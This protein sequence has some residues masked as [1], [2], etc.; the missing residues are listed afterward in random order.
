MQALCKQFLL[1]LLFLILIN[2]NFV[3]AFPSYLD[4]QGILR[5]ITNGN[6]INRTET[7]NITIYNYSNDAV[8]YTE[9]KAITVVNGV[10]NYQIGYITPLVPSIFDA[11]T[12]FKTKIDVDVLTSVNFTAVPYSFNSLNCND[13]DYLGGTSSGSYA[14][15]TELSDSISNNMTA[16]KD[17]ITANIT[18]E[19]TTMR[20][21]VDSVASDTNTW[22]TINETVLLNNTNILTINNTWW[23]ANYITPTA[24]A[25][26]ISGN[27]TAIDTAIN[28]NITASDART[29]IKINNNITLV[30]GWITTNITEENT[31][32][33]DYVDSVA[34]DTDTHHPLNYTTITN[35]TGDITINETWVD[36]LWARITS[37]SD[38]MIQNNTMIKSWISGNDTLVRASIVTNITLEN[39]TMKGY[40]DARDTA[41]AATIGTNITE[42]NTTMK[43]YVDT[44][45]SAQDECSEIT[46]CVENALINGSSIQALEIN[47]TQNITIQVNNFICFGN[48]SHP[49]ARYM[50]ANSS[51]IV[52]QG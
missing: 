46:G 48:S 27:R 9:Q 34:A 14:T 37:V 11:S 43:A 44:A 17:W 26:S 12:Y 24:L 41:I 28:N 39:T 51:H 1:F 2:C 6:L 40:V 15:N 32:M 10:W 31:T 45:D 21:Y 42:E 30:K 8:L 19:N 7:F 23:N 4:Q 33:R 16:V 50:M 13:S 22:W 47:V 18:E 49:C 38:W 52:I 5:N 36:T 20:D 29:D 25:N 3:L 35:T